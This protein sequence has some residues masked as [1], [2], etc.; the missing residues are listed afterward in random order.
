MSS[1]VVYSVIVQ[2]LGIPE[3]FSCVRRKSS[4]KQNTAQR[5]VSGTKG[6]LYTSCPPNYLALHFDT[7][8]SYFLIFISSA[9]RSKKN[10][11]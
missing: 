11:D 2:T 10:N 6:T 5:N 8:S 7:M 9:L 4:D 3:V 1:V